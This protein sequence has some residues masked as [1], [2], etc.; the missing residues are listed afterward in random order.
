MFHHVEQH[1]DT[2]RAHTSSVDCVSN[3]AADT[4]KAFIEREYLSALFVDIHSAY[5]IVHIPTLL[6]T[7][8]NIG[9][10]SPSPN[11]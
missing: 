4:Y 7:M 5:P 10:P 9:M 8:M 11:S 2:I 1:Q 3:L 6:K